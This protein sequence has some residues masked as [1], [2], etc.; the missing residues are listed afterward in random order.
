MYKCVE[1]LSR[2]RASVG[3]PFPLCCEG[4]GQESSMMKVWTRLN[5]AQDG[6]KLHI[7]HQTLAGHSIELPRLGLVRHAL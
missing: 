2:V 7:L 5:P 6:N 1:C 4:G 3:E